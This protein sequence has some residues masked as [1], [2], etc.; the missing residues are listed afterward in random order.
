MEIP[1]YICPRAV[2][3]PNL[4]G[5]LIDPTWAA[6]PWTEDFMDIQGPGHPKPRFRT[7]AKMMWDDRC[8]Y[9]GAE[10]EEPHVWGT[11]TEHDSVI[12]QDNDFEVF[13]DPDGDGH[14]YVEFEINALNTTWDLL[15]VK[16]YLAGGPPVDGFELRGI[17]TAVHVNGTLNDP[18]DVDQGWTV[19]IAIPWSALTQVAGMSCPPRQGDQWRINFS[20]VEWEHLVADGQYRKIPARAED[21]W[22]WSP[23]GVIDMHRPDRW[24]ILQFASSSDEPVRPY[25]GLAERAVLAR[26]WHA[27]RAFREHTGR[28]STSGL[29]LGIS[30]P[31]VIHATP[32]QYE[33][34]LN[35]YR[36]N[37]E[38]RVTGP[39]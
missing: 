15:L 37:Q 33:A 7:R 26:L 9:I 4:D 31:V 6:A 3:P 21:N 24:G 30:E 18:S 12:F 34:E 16:P 32:N 5:R 19:E 1:T 36:I 25:P 39:G 13:L 22:V 8:L 29:E 20:R 38:M 23:Q 28:W 11:L 17:R 2:N 14:R 27:Q 10:L 35:G